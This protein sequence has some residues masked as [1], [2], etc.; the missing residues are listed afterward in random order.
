MFTCNRDF[1]YIFVWCASTAIVNEN[2]VIV[3]GVRCFYGIW[4]MCELPGRE[5]KKLLAVPPG[6]PAYNSSPKTS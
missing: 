5:P 4:R 3:N 1:F 6:E 2:E